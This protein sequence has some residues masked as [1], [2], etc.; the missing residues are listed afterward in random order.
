MVALPEAGGGDNRVHLSRAHRVPVHAAVTG[1]FQFSGRGPLCNCLG[2]GHLGSCHALRGWIYPPV[3][4]LT[5]RVLVCA[6]RQ[7]DFLPL[8]IVYDNL[9]L[10]K[11]LGPDDY[12][13]ASATIYFDIVNLYIMIRG[14]S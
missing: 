1:R 8:Y 12:I 4:G 11:R 10:S 5:P 2:A 3:I 7:R 6:D 13:Q 9:L 14:S